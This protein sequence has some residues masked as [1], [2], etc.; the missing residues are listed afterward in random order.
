MLAHALR[1]RRIGPSDV[2]ATK[3]L[4]LG[5]LKNGA[6]LEELLR[7]PEITIDDLLFIDADLAGLP[8]AVREQLEIAVKYNGY[9]QRQL[10]QVERF[11]RIEQVL[12]PGDF[13]YDGISGLSREVQEKLANAR[14]Q[15]LGQA[16][17][18]PGVTP[19]AV[20]ILSVLLRRK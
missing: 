19:A 10:E 12:I 2:E 18:I 17:R 6:T 3:R 5:E 13:D 11:R 7:R 4:G 20:A 16:G 14:P 8:P 1:S 9:I 15:T